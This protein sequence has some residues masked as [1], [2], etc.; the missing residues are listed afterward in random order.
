MKIAYWTCA[1]LHMQVRSQTLRALLLD[2]APKLATKV[3]EARSAQLSVWSDTT[4]EGVAII[5]E[6]LI[7]CCLARRGS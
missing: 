6:Q 7:S 1:A 4:L 3:A 2:S 5:L